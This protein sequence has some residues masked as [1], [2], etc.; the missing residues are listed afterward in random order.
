MIRFSQGNWGLSK[1]NPEGFT[2]SPCRKI[3]QMFIVI[4][5][6]R[7][8]PIY[9]QKI[10]VIRHSYITDILRYTYVAIY[11]RCTTTVFLASKSFR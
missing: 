3:I 5:Q 9:G 1:K 11:V 8:M 10:I 7:A 2:E 4:Q 6:T